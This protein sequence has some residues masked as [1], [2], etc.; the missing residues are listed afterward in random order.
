MPQHEYLYFFSHTC[1]DHG[2]V[3]RARPYAR[4]MMLPA[5]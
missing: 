3:I 2:Y 1:N 4:D 5:K